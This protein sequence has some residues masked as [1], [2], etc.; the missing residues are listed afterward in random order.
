MSIRSP[1][2][3]NYEKINTFKL[4][5]LIDLFAKI[6]ISSY[7]ACYAIQMLS[8]QQKYRNQEGFNL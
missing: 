7:L 2:T 4:I 8:E 6:I 1:A 3:A 5:E